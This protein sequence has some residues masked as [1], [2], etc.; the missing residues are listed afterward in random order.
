M[1]LS[2]PWPAIEQAIAERAV[3][4]YKITNLVSV[5]GG[6]IS[7]SYHVT[8]NTGEYFVKLNGVQ[9]S[10]MFETEAVGLQAL[11]ETSDLR[12]PQV[13]CC[14]KTGSDAYLVLEWLDLSS[15]NQQANQQLG[16]RLAAM[17]AVQQPHYGWQDDNFIGSTAQPNAKNHDWVDFVRQQRLGYQ[18]ELAAANGA[19]RSLLDRGQQL[20]EQLSTF[21][22]NYCPQPSLIHGDL[23]AGNFAMLAD[24]QPAI[25]DP[26]CYYGDREAEIAMTELFGGFSSAF[27]SAYNTTFALD[28][29]YQVRKQL[30]LLY[31]VLN[32]FNLFGSSYAGQAQGLIDSLL[33][34]C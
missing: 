28:S 7:A 6:S 8:G 32:H 26:A 21:F 20:C 18:L 24:S 33:A 29:G 25:F 3:V 9:A 16:E 17:H 27:Y 34:E 4:N 2:K 22:S 1:Q 19:S 11:A 13:V 14:G 5:G 15:A 30:Y 31:H 12:I 23:W 10:A